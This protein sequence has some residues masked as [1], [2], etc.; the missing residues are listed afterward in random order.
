MYVCVL[1]N[2]IQHAPFVES[3][4]EI[5]FKIN[6]FPI[7]YEII[8]LQNYFS[9]FVIIDQSDSKN[10]KTVDSSYLCLGW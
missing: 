4:T 3:S 10:L 9:V 7:K 1:L 6:N 8:F 5:P 2:T